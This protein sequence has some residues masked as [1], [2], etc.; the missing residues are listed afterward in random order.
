MTSSRN[1][2]RF[3]DESDQAFSI[4]NAVRTELSWTHYR[5]LTAFPLVAEPV[6]VAALNA[7]RDVERR[8]VK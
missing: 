1:L 7:Y 2:C 3:V 8:L 5:T 4:W 6:K